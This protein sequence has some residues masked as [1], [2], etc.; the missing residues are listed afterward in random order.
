[1]GPYSWKLP[2]MVWAGSYR[3]DLGLGCSVRNRLILDL[4]QK[5]AE[6]LAQPLSQSQLRCGR[7]HPS[8]R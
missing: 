1:M 3:R 7:P 2:F 6:R 5:K 4:D 8:P